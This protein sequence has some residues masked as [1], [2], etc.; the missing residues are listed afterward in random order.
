MFNFFTL[1]LMLF[2][3]ILVQLF[4]MMLEPWEAEKSLL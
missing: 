2:G 4:Q 1:F 3:K